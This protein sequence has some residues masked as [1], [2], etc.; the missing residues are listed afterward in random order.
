VSAP[1]VL[2]IAGS[3]RRHGNSDRLLE[4]ALAGARDAGAETQLFVASAAVMRP[5]TGCNSCALTGEC[6]L[7]DGGSAFYAA[8]DR[9]DALIVASPVYFATVPAV[10]K[11]AIDRLQP[12]WARRYALGMPPG[13]RR[14]GA[15]LLARSGGDPFGFSAAEATIASAFAVLGIDI[16]GDVKVEG[17]DSP[18]DLGEHAEAL[19]D[20]RSLGRAVAAEAARRLSGRS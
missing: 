17:V 16:V 2:G 4:A 11:I 13:P 20:A 8:L 5:C 6:V 1:V 10:L 15:I 18:A 12:Y 19:Q 14:P 9:A 3:P 7:H